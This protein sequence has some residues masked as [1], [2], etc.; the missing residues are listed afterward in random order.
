[1]GGL[2][3]T[4]FRGILIEVQLSFIFML[5][6][7]FYGGILHGL[8]TNAVSVLLLGFASV[9]VHELG[10]AFVS[11]LLGVPVVAI[12]LHAFGGE[13]RLA[14][15]PR[16]PAT[17]VLIAAAGPVASLLCAA[18]AGLWLWSSGELWAEVL[19]V[20]NL[21]LAG[22]NLVPALPLDGGRVLRAALVPRYGL[23]R[24]TELA[25]IVARVIA[26][27]A[28]VIGPIAGYWI[29][30]PL[31]GLLWLSAG[32][33]RQALERWCFSDVGAGGDVKVLDA[34]GRPAGRRS[35]PLGTTY[36]IEEHRSA[37]GR[38]WVVRDFSGTVLL[39]TDTPLGAD[40]QPEE[41]AEEPVAPPE[42]GVFSL[43]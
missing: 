37:L 27:A 36:V 34:E 24:A 39:V 30:V 32:R 8:G 40:G 28:A 9:L 10:H 43:M 33:E 26:V 29:F 18:G 12:S 35:T 25:I 13:T 19:V 38:R 1:M 15:F 20:V 21:I 4:R 3:L 16:R 14:A 6:A 23:R 41:P 42:N 17:E 7:A 22:S 11:R 31:A 5:M 2:R